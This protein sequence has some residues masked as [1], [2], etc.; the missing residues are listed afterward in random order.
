MP[1]VPEIR[2]KTGVMQH[3]EADMATS[4]PAPATL[5]A[6]SGAALDD[7]FIGFCI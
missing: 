3:N 2:A 5:P 6:L 7:L 4:K 1:E